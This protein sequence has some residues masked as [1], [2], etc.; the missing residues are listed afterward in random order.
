ME[1]E[2]QINFWR[3]TW[4]REKGY[5]LNLIIKY[6]D[7]TEAMFDYVKDPEYMTEADSHRGICFGISMV[8]HKDISEPDFVEYEFNLHFDDQEK[9]E[10][11]NVPNQRNPA[12]DPYA[13]V[14]DLASYELYSSQGFN[15]MQNWCA[16]SVL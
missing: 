9:S 4:T 1:I 11:Q 7:S 16:N 5:F 8:K 13:E 6:F 12:F 10:Y 3:N 15:L 14:A 2:R